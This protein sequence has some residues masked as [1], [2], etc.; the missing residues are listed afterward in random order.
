MT[1]G[2]IDLR[3]T[4][5]EARGA[6]IMAAFEAMSIGETLTALTGYDPRAYAGSLEQIWPGEV[7]CRTRRV[8]E[9]EWSITLSRTEPRAPDASPAGVLERSWVFSSLCTNTRAAIAAAATVCEAGKGELIVDTTRPADYLGIVCDGTIALMLGRQSPQRI[10][11]ELFPGDVFGEV[12][13]FDEG[14]LL[15]SFIVL[16]KTARYMTVPFTDLRALAQRDPALLFAL[17]T[18]CAQHARALSSGLACQVSQPII[19]RVARAL[20]PYAVVDAGLR[21]SLPPLSAMTQ[22]QIAAAAGTVKE[23]AAR[24]ICELENRGALRRERGH[25]VYLDRVGLVNIIERS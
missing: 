14:M 8:G 9:G 24:A 16:S 6:A 11:H 13:F 17:G 3:G 21:P 22:S 12:A 20:L 23:V 19:A 2:R 5:L 1:V 18:A 15:G 4:G 25:I 10:L 7:L